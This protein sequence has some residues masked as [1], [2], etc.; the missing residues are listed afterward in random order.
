MRLAI[1][2]LTSTVCFARIPLPLEVSYP[3]KTSVTDEFTIS[4]LNEHPI[5]VQMMI[6]GL[7]FDTVLAAIDQGTLQD[8]RTISIEGPTDGIAPGERLTTDDASLVPPNTIVRSV[9]GQNV[10]LSQAI[11]APR[12]RRTFYFRIATPEASIQINGCE[13]IPLISSNIVFGLNGR[14]AEGFRV[15]RRL[16]LIT[17]KVPAGELR[18]GK[19]TFTFTFEKSDGTVSALR[20]LFINFYQDGDAL[21]GPEEISSVDFTQFM[22]PFTDSA[23]IAAGLGAYQNAA[24]INRTP[25]DEPVPTDE[26]CTSCHSKDGSDIR[27]F[28][29]SPMTITARSMFHGLSREVGEEIASYILSLK[30]PHPGMPWSVEYSDQHRLINSVFKIS[31]AR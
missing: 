29:Y 16:K 15:G 13:R 28:N 11:S 22:P 20:V 4:K 25:R 1:V 27:Y 21:I 26:H 31:P 5:T 10:N 8:D 14:A 30:T 17:M 12:A 18:P 7:M 6:H 19:N 9:I 2:F 23:H 24:L 3:L